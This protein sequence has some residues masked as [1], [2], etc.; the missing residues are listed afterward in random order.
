MDQSAQKGP[1]RDDD[2]TGS[3]LP[4]IAQSDAGDPAVRDDQLVRFAF[5]HTEIGGLPDRRLHGR[6]VKLAIGL[7]ARAADS[8]TLAP[9]QHPKLDA[10]GIGDPAHQTV[11]GIDL[12]DQ[13]TLAETA[14]GGIAGHRA[15]GGETMG[16]Q[17]G[18]GA[19]P[20]SGAR[21]F[22]AGMAAA[23][24]DDVEGVCSGIH[25]GTSIAEFK[26]PEVEV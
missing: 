22:T 20:R 8:R 2:G 10:A 24:H 11:Q 6:G 1:G 7:G 15:D 21:G 13:M 16:H 5:D 4:A 14:N 18:P 3:E 25:G 17:G 12:A 9:V 23:D 26:N 19:H